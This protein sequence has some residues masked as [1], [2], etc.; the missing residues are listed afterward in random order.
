MATL[1]QSLAM[2]RRRVG[3][4]WLSF[5]AWIA[6]CGLVLPAAEV[7]RIQRAV[8]AKALEAL[9]VGNLAPG[10]E[11]DTWKFSS[12]ARNFFGGGWW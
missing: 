5:A 8:R 12:L 9:A 6:G 10:R 7:R 2:P 11:L 3:L 1:A 4:P